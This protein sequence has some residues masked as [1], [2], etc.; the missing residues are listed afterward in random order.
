MASIYVAVT[1]L[2]MLLA[3]PRL[4]GKLNVT[5]ARVLCR[6]G[7]I[8]NVIHPKSPVLI[9]QGTDA[10]LALLRSFKSSLSEW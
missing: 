3:C 10:V 5:P 6:A 1:K 9:V 7:E 2:G 4:K 8:V